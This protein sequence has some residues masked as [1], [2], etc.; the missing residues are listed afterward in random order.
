MF[1]ISILLSPAETN[2][3]NKFPS[4]V[5]T[6]AIGLQIVKQKQFP[7]V[8]VTLFPQAGSDFYCLGGGCGMCSL[9]GTTPLK[10]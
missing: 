10:Q 1:S 3:E 7:E 5:H 4:K 6:C 9:L 8:Q 2:S